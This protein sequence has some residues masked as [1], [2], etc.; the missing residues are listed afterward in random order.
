MEVRYSNC[1]LLK[2]SIEAKKVW[3]LDANLPVSKNP[4]NCSKHIQSP[5]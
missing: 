3:K 4:H 2:L 5:Y 1:A